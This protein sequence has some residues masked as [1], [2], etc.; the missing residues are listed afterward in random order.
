MWEG[1]SLWGGNGRSFPCVD[2]QM[3]DALWKL[4]DCSLLS[5]VASWLLPFS[6][7]IHTRAAHGAPSAL[8]D[9]V[10]VGLWRRNS[11][12]TL[13]AIRK[14]AGGDKEGR[15]SVAQCWVL[16]GSG[17]AGARHLSRCIPY[18]LALVAP[19]D[20]PVG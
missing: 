19:A 20:D 2:V 15:G 6:P 10:M 17:L 4:S 18:G 1:H 3:S 13:E 5:G 8:P 14:D 7:G 11:E 12:K 16:D 9:A